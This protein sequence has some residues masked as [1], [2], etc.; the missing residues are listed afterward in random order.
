MPDSAEE[1]QK[2]RPSQIRPHGLGEATFHQ[3]HGGVATN[4][5]EAPHEM[6]AQE[7]GKIRGRNYERPR[8]N[9]VYFG[10]LPEILKSSIKQSL[11]AL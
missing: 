3:V 8:T 7:Y 5:P 4:N 1:S 10:E 11:S 2:S 9:V 6:F